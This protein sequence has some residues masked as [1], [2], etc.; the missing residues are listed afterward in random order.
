[1]AREVDRAAHVLAGLGSVRG[2][3]V[4]ACLPNDVD[5]VVAFLAAMRI[6]A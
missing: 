3:R 5:I 6:A 4:A 1:M 2:D